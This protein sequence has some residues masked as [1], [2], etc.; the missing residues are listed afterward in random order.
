[1]EAVVSIEDF[2]AKADDADD[3]AP[4]LHAVTNERRIVRVG[5]LKPEPAILAIEAF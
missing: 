4:D 3:D 1:M 2:G 5:G